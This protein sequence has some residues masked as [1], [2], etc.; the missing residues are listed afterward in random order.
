M[1]T[2]IFTE[3]SRIS[4]CL[5]L[6]QSE[7]QKHL[8]DYF[9][10]LDHLPESVVKYHHLSDGQISFN[11]QFLATYGSAALNDFHQL[12]M[13]ELISQFSQRVAHLKLPESIHALYALEFERILNLIENGKDFVFDWSNDLFAKDMGICRLHL[14]PAGARLL[15]IT[16]FSRRPFVSN[17]RQLLPNLYFL[18]FKVKAALPLYEMH[19]HVSNLKDFHPLGWRQCLVRIGQLLKLNPQIHG[20]HGTSWFYDPVLQDVSPHLTYLRDIPC[21]NGAKTF[22]VK[23]DDADSEAFRKSKSRKLLFLD[24]KYTPKLFLLIWPRNELIT[25]SDQ[26]LHLLTSAFCQES[27]T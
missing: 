19:V 8:T 12:I 23:D 22:F 7:L 18:L 11:Q 16:G 9:F 27:V 3:Q 1:H 6:L 21:Q 26:N 24:K 17:W 2:R 13:L 4:D 14:I 10:L 20:L 5:P 15:E 25:F